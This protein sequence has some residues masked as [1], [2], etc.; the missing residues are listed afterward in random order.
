MKLLAL[1]LAC[2]LPLTSL[3]AGCQDLG[4]NCGLRLYCCGEDTGE[5]KCIGTCI[6]NS[7]HASEAETSAHLRGAIEAVKFITEDNGTCRAQ[8]Q[9]CG[10]NPDQVCCPGLYCHNG[11]SPM[12]RDKY[13]YSQPPSRGAIEAVKFITEDERCQCREAGETCEKGPRFCHGL[14]SQGGPLGCYRDPNGKG[15][16]CQP[17]R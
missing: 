14:C 15:N 12:L 1:V 10:R 8:G 6:P 5:T 16:V 4:E 9:T 7:N 11:D 17:C 2:A 3:V 13:C